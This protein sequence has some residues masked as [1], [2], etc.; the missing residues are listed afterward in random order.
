M[1]ITSIL[2]ILVGVIGL[3]SSTSINILER[4][5]E[6]GVMR[7]IGA[8]PNKIASM[9]IYENVILGL[10]SFVSSCIIAIPLTIILSNKFG[11]I[12]LKAPLS[13]LYSPHAI[14]GWFL[15]TMLI[16]IAVSYF[17]AKRSQLK[18][19]NELISYE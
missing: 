19:V 12:F 9:I 16:A 15:A 6:I 14:L 8:S 11:K 1:I 2:I 5:R 4:I 3:I 7:A 18:P 13:I 17:V 10:I